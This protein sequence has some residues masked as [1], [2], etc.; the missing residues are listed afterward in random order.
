MNNQEVFDKVV[1][2]LYTQRARSV[3]FDSTCLYRGRHDRK[4]AIGALIPDDIYH[5]CIER[6]GIRNLI[7]PDYPSFDPEIAA[8]FKEADIELLDDLQY[9]HDGKEVN[10]WPEELRRRGKQY[11]LD[12]S[13]VKDYV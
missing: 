11:K 4:C 1:E 3:D 5:P 7:D 8:L 12:I 13:K 10:K 9:I 2:H 6:I